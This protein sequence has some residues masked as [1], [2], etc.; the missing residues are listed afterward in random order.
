MFIL[1]GFVNIL[2][3]YQRNLGSAYYPRMNQVLVL[4]KSAYTDILMGLLCIVLFIFVNPFVALF[5]LAIIARTYRIPAFIFIV[6]ASIS[7]ALFF[8]FREY[9]VAWDPSSTDDVPVYINF[10]NMNESIGFWGIFVRFIA[11]PSGYEPLWNILWWPLIN[12]FGAS[13]NV[14]VF[15]HYTL[16]FVAVFFSF[17]ILSR[18]YFI[19]LAL[20]YF[21][22]A[23]MS[24]DS[25]THIWRQQL[26][27]SLFLIG[28][29]YYLVH[30]NTKGKWLIY[31]SPLM[32][33]SSIFFVAVFL[34]FELYKKYAG[35]D[36]RIKFATITGLIFVTLPIMSS[37]VISYLSSIGVPKIAGYF[38]GSGDDRSRIFLRVSI[39][40]ILLLILHLKLISDDLN[41]FFI[42]T[43]LAV[44][45]FMFAFP[46][47]NSIYDRFL[48]FSLP[49]FGLYLFRCFLI[50]FS[51]RW[52][53]LIIL[54][55]FVTGA[56]RIYIPTLNDVGAVRFLANGH[57]FDPFM[58][59]L[60]MLIYL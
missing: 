18:K 34:V 2:S 35:F 58:G 1:W 10:Y 37:V 21:F 41:N 16:I 52:H 8:Y 30:G 9:G 56:I 50:N 36:N 54:F 14:F 12:I 15:L 38:E 60:K 4:N 40:V 22:I 13:N 57:A 5:F 48:M 44:F 7:F 26:A 32:H 6:S 47:S 51:V 33:L 28:I 43:L 17:F 42:I 31:I 49:F 29:G 59:S 45:S 11:V 25:I 3:D 23:P 46:G 24:I 20:V 39:V 19:T 55:V 27:F 53:L